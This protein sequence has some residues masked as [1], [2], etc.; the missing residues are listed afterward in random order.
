MEQKQIKSRLEKAVCAIFM[1]ALRG[2]KIDPMLIS[3]VKGDLK[4]LKEMGIDFQ[5][6]D[7]SVKAE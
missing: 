6:L 3:Q 1:N 4:E 2:D 5:K 7:V